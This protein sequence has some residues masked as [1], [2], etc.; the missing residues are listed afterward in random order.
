MID[1]GWWD[2]ERKNAEKGRGTRFHGAVIMP[3]LLAGKAPTHAAVGFS[4]VDL[5]G[6]DQN[7]RYTTPHPCRL[8]P[9]WPRPAKLGAIN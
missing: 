8:L 3:F 1:E 7:S 4:L 2:A 9:A 6:S 5:P